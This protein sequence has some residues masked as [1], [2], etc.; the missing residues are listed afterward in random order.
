MEKVKIFLD[1]LFFSAVSAAAVLLVVA[2]LL[3]IAVEDFSITN[4][5]WLAFGLWSLVSIAS[6]SVLT[7]RT[8]RSRPS[9]HIEYTRR[10]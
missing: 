1:H 2:I 3:G 7:V 8:I 4:H 9:D 5:G 6:A 10:K